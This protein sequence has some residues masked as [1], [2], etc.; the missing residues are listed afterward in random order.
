M[1]G[2]IIEIERFAIHDGPGI[3][4]TVFLKGCPL[5][6]LWCQN[7]EGKINKI[8]LWYFE[9]KCIHCHKCVSS[10]RNKAL[11]I[12]EEKTGPHILINRDKCKNSASCVFVCPTEALVFDGENISSDEVV[13]ILLRDKKFYRNSGGG[14]TISGGDPLYQYEF[15]IE[16]LKSCKENKIHTAIETCLYA[17]RKIVDRFIDIVDLFIVDLKIWNTELHE[18]YTGKSNKLIKSNFEY[19]SSKGV[20][21]LVRIPLVPGITA[22]KDNIRDIAGFVSSV[23]ADIPIELINFNNF[24]ESKYRNMGIDNEIIRRNKP[25]NKKELEEFYKIILDKNIRVEKEIIAKL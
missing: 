22:L 19:L 6:C 5:N 13:E 1:E 17:E 4:S 16:I 23:N 12:N 9:S 21:M 3:R 14:I 25:L 10:C 24:C 2:N 7:P 20:K 18:K 8:N 15:A 11:S